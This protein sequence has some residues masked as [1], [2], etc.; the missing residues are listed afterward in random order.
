MSLF[1]KKETA[2]LRIGGMTCANCQR[3]VGEALRGVP[4]VASASVD[5]AFHRA[6]VTYDPQKA[7]VDDLVHAVQEA[8]Y[9]AQ[10]LPAK[11]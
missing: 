6:S 5:L 2:T 11:A 10:P 3:H 4:G 1:A 7:K 9:E 8:G